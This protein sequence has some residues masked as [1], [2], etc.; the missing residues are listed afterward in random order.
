MAFLNNSLFG[1]VDGQTAAQV[2]AAI[3]AALADYSTT[4]QM[5]TAIGDALT[6]ALLS[7]PLGA[8]VQTTDDTPTAL[9]GDATYPLTIANNT[10]AVFQLYVS[11]RKTNTAGANGGYLFQG[12]VK[13][14]ANAASTAIVGSVVKTVIAEDDSNWDVAVTADTT[15]GGLTITVTGVAATTIKWEAT[16]TFTKVVGAIV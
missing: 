3:A 8:D 11:G 15:G 2:D 13:R 1:F 16:G 12:V 4:A 6:A 5:N 9:T 7:Y 10:T 14:D